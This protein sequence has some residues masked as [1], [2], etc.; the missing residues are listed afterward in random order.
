MTTLPYLPKY[1]AKE[2][3]RPIAV[4]KQ[5][6]I[7]SRKTCFPNDTKPKLSGVEFRCKESDLLI[8]D[9]ANRLLNTRDL[10]NHQALK[11]IH[12]IE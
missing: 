1:L 5:F 2:S 7:L 12:F 8:V 10:S 3:A 9:L 6:T 4:L 11:E